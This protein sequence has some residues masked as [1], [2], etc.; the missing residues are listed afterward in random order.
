M[1]S[2]YD[3]YQTILDIAGVSWEED[4]S[5]PGQS[6]APL[7]CGD[8]K[9]QRKNSVVVL[10]EY[11]PCRMLRTREWKLVLRLPNGPDEL[12]DL[13][14]DP[15]EAENLICSPRHQDLVSQLKAELERWFARYV[16]P[17]FD[18][19]KEAVSG[20]GQLARHSFL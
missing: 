9:W 11:G 1:I 13:Q 16:D 6:F 20:H 2:H 14:N 10:D 8:A 18:G 17:Q 4:T 7:I 19:S 3:F 12:Y 5:M 15:D